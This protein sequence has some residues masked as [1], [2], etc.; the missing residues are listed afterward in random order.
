MKICTSSDCMIVT[1]Q[2]QMQDITGSIRGA[3]EKGADPMLVYIMALRLAVSTALQWD[4]NIAKS[5][6][7]SLVAQIIAPSYWEDEDFPHSLTL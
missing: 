6:I 5:N 1:F 7:I 3:I 2:S 4:P